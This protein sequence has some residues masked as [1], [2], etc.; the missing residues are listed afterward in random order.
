[1]MMMVVVASRL[2]EN[3]NRYLLLLFLNVA[4]ADFAD[5]NIHIWEKTTVER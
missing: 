2:L 3:S 5:A 4:A 1:M